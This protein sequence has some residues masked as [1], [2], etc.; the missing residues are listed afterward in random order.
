MIRMKLLVVLLAALLVA[1]FVKAATLNT[2][3]DGPVR[4]APDLTFTRLK[5]GPNTLSAMRGKVVVLDF[6]ATWCGPC[7]MAIPE[8]QKLY[9]KHKKDGLQVIGIS[10]DEPET[11]PNI[12]QVQK[13][14]GM[15]YPVL[16]ASEVPDVRTKYQ[17]SGIPALFVIDRKGVIRF[18]LDGYSP[19]VIDKIEEILKES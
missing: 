17:F 8:L 12:P 2:G 3:G 9:V 11:Q 10:V 16:L 14:L 18:Q 5:D 4:P 6:W 19:V 7:R 1:L 13:E 15:T